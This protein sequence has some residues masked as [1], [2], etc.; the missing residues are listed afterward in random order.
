M[1]PRQAR[2]ARVHDALRAAEVAFAPRQLREN[3]ATATLAAAALGCR[4][5]QI[6][7]TIVFRTAAAEAKAEGA[8]LAVLCGDDRVA[9]EQLAALAGAPLHKAD[10]QFVKRH[11]GFEI[12]GV[13]PLAPLQPVRVFL[14]QRLQ[15]FETIWAAAGSAY[16][17]FGIAP[18]DLC[19][20]S[21]GV[22]AAFADS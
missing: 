2:I 7:K 11:C 20:A 5:A 16:A 12:G 6:A 13:A 15:R 14:E 10:A 3:T 22:F 21:G 19:R 8:V 17:V 9:V 4:V 18:A 1:P